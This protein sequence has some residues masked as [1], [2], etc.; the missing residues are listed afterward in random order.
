MNT[1]QKIT[2]FALMIWLVW[3][4]YWAICQDN[5]KANEELVAAYNRIQELSWLI[6]NESDNWW[7]AEDAKAECIQSWNQQ[8][9]KANKQADIYRAEKSRL[10]G[11]IERSQPQKK[12]SDTVESWSIMNDTAEKTEDNRWYKR[13][14]KWVGLI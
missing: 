5:A 1:Q 11:L 2:T 8:Q 10:E 14:L 4:T 12:I 7:I 13:L 6:E 3:F 9:E